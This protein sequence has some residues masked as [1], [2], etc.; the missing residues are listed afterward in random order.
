MKKGV[1]WKKVFDDGAGDLKRCAQL[2]VLNL[3]DEDEKGRRR[4]Q[5]E[6]GC[7]TANIEAQ[8]V[9]DSYSIFCPPVL[10]IGVR[11]GWE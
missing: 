5:M 3:E 6:Q 8:C 7:L 9:I 2:R 1:L 4:G 10:S 11:A